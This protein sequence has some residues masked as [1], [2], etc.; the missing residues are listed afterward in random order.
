[1]CTKDSRTTSCF[2]FFG[3]S[4]YQTDGGKQMATSKSNLL[5][6]L[7]KHGQINI[8]VIPV[9]DTNVNAQKCK[10]LIL[11]GWALIRRQRADLQNC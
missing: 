1:M 8:P 3:G 11:R 9:V 4:K 10:A 5:K 2:T 7:L 6:M